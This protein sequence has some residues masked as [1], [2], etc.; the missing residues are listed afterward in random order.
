MVK[1]VVGEEMQLK[2][3][4]ERLTKS[5]LAAQVGL[6][7][8]KL[9][10][11]LDRGFIF[12]LIPTPLNDAGEPACSV[13]DGAKDDRKKGSKGKTQADSSTLF[14]DRDWV[15][16]HARQVRRM[17]L[18]GVKVVGIYI[19]A[20]ESSFKNSTITICQTI[21]AVAKA[22]PFVDSDCDERLL[23]HI[24]Y[25]PMRWTTRNCSLSS[26]ITSSNLRPCDFKMGKVLFSLQTFR[27]RYAFDLRLPIHRENGSNNIR[28]ADVLRHCISFIAKELKCAKPLV[29]GKLPARDEQVA[30]D[31]VH[32]VEFLLPFLQDQFD[33]CSEKNIIGGLVF[34]GAICSYA[35][36]NAKEPLSQALADIKEDIIMSLQSRLD[37]ICDVAERE[38]EAIGGSPEAEAMGQISTEE[39]V[40]LLPL[41]SQMKNIKQ[42]FPRRVFLPWLANVY[43]C[44]YIQPSET[45]EVVNDHCAELMSMEV[46]IDSSKVL[47]P[48]LEAPTFA[49]PAINNTQP[50]WDIMNRHSSLSKHGDAKSSRNDP[51]SKGSAGL[52]MMVPILILILSLIIGVVMLAVR[53]S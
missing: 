20:S 2:I 14:V 25:S 40:P 22:A 10:S 8:G 29:D 7:I 49:S 47:E 35:Y 18:G 48:E 12:D 36:S 31:G 16:E 1:A 38:S 34:T 32:D 37:I 52:N 28:L 17:L 13:I 27:C 24:C 23:V 11:S 9:S 26:N 3:A 15:A 33:G 6:V 39:P 53:S 30:S 45:V 46:P 4:E 42:L 41:Q 21:Q 50:L 5:G 43:V 19:W 44:D 51:K